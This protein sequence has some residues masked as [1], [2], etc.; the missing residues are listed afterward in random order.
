MTTRRRSWLALAVCLLVTTLEIGGTVPAGSSVSVRNGEFRTWHSNGRLADV[1]RYRD[2][3]EEGL[4]QSWT[5]D[6]V[7][8]L[9]YEVRHGRRYGL[10]NA[11]PCQPVDEVRAKAGL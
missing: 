11:R 3:R 6:G 1:R 2:G 4:Q 7:L 8:Y 10:V 5:A 9:N